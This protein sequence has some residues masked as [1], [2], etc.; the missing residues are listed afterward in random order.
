MVINFININK[1]NNHITDIKAEKT[2]TYDNGN[3]GPYWLLIDNNCMLY[4]LI[5]IAKIKDFS[6]VHQIALL[7]NIESR[8]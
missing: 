5:E 7:C 8:C 6:R 1:T 3:P 4:I 2:T